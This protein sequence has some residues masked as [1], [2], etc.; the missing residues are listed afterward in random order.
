VTTPKYPGQNDDESFC[1][2]GHNWRYATTEEK[3]RYD[4]EGH[5]DVTSKPKG[6]KALNYYEIY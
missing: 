5:F 2:N 6:P 1:L 4:A 3:I